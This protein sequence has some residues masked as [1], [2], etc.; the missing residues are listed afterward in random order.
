MSFGEGRLHL[1]QAKA[2]LPLLTSAV[3]LD[4]HDG[5]SSSHHRF[6][7]FGDGSKVKIFE[8]Y[9]YPLK[10]DHIYLSNLVPFFLSHTH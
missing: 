6:R 2:S 3:V 10:N 1:P 8:I 4:L 7:G 9:N 5:S